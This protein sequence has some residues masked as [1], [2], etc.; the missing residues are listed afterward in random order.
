LAEYAVRISAIVFVPQKRIDGV[1]RSAKNM[2]RD[3][4]KGSQNHKRKNASARTL[5]RSHGNKRKRPQTFDGK[6]STSS[7]Q[8]EVIDLLRRIQLSISKDDSQS[9]GTKNATSNPNPS[10]ESIVQVLPQSPKQR[11]RLKGRV[12]KF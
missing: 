2:G 9:H 7:D 8:R 5:K 10:S 11:L 6:K 4:E 1:Q 3:G 12:L